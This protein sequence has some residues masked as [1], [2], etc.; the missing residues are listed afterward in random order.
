MKEVK[1]PLIQNL[2]LLQMGDAVQLLANY[3]ASLAIDEVNWPASFPYAPET[4]VRV[5]HTDTHLFLL[6]SVKGLQLRALAVE[7]HQSVWE[8]SCVEFFCR[9]PDSAYYMNFEANCI[10]TMTASRR[11]SK[12]EDV[13]KLLPEEMAQIHRWTTC[14]RRRIDGQ[15]GE[16]EWQVLLAIPLSLIFRRAL[17]FPE[18]LE[19][20]FYK[21]A[22]KTRYPHFVSWNPIILPT[23]NF[24]CPQ[25][26]GRLVLTS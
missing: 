21:C 25:F 2:N 5:A 24:H 14:E 20:N 13:H 18:T 16:F 6:Y 1:V 26:F 10:G 23:P 11:I 17:S 12:K 9:V 15:D 22:D 7:D 4:N 19:A 8:D 3:G